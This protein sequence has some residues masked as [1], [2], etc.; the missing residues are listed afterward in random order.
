M[1]TMLQSQYFFLGGV[2]RRGLWTVNKQHVATV[3]MGLMAI[4]LKNGQIAQK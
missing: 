4:T 1:D 3:N 2:L